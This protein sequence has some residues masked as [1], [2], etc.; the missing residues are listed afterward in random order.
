[1]ANPPKPIEQLSAQELCDLIASG[2]VKLTEV[3][4][5]LWRA[6]RLLLAAY[7]PRDLKS[8]FPELAL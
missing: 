1:M 7:V 8:P 6:R 3:N 4:D 5:I 2:S